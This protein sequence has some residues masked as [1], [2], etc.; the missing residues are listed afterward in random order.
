MS[1][2]NEYCVV[3]GEICNVYFTLADTEKDMIVNFHASEKPDL[4]W[5]VYDVVSHERNGS[6]ED[7][8][9]SYPFRA[10]ATTYKVL[11]LILS[12][13][14]LLFDCYDC[15]VGLLYL[16]VLLDGYSA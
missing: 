5:A 2:H 11:Q 3:E 1:T 9:S 16:F 12:H 13:Y 4:A 7:W 14:M 15:C 10:S 6:V 8:V